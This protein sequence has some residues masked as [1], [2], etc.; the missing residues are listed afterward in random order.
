[1]KI[2][3]GILARMG[4]TR[5]P[6]KALE[7]LGGVSVLELLVKRLQKSKIITQIFVA[8]TLTS[9]DDAIEDFCREAGIEC[10]RGSTDNV[11]DRLHNAHKSYNSDLC[12]NIYGDCPFLDVGIV[13]DFVNKIMHETSN[14]MFLGNDLT[15]T[16]PPGMEVEVFPFESLKIA[17]ENAT[18]QEYLEHATLYLRKELPRDSIVNVIASDRYHRPDLSFELDTEEDLCLLREVLKSMKNH[19]FT[20]ADLIDFMDKNTHLLDITTNVSRRWRKYRDE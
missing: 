15:T 16:Y 20:L 19:F 13:D 12:I 7:D 17:F 1:M 8:T 18:K 4:S 11:L 14:C 2:N 9:E 3:L 10:Y 6:S 5:L